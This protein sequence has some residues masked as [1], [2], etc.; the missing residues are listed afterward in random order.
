MPVRHDQF[1]AVEKPDDAG[2]NPNPTDHS[3]VRLHLH[4]IADFHRLL[5]EEDQAGDEIVHD[6]L[7]TEAD[8]N[9]ERAGKDGELRHVDSERGDRDEKPDE[10]NDVMQE[11]RDGVGRSAIKMEPIVNILLEKEADEAREQ[12][13]DPDREDEGENGAEGDME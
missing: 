1:R 6:I 9:T 4:H 8:A 13:R 5:E 7:Q 2:A 3:D 11:R 12:R 10:Q